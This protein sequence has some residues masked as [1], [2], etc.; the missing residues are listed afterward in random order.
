MANTK[1]GL[2]VSTS[3][4]TS[5]CQLARPIASR[6]CVVWATYARSCLPCHPQ[7]VRKQALAASAEAPHTGSGELHRLAFTTP[8]ATREQQPSVP[9]D[10]GTLAPPTTMLW[11]Q[12]E[13]GSGFCALRDCCH[14]LTKNRAGHKR[15]G[16]P[17]ATWQT[18]RPVGPCC[19]RGKL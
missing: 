11:V 18:K 4:H 12:A 17:S 13:L 9:E 2:H 5:S 6:S 15:T 19:S 7:R 1:P 8:G 3:R 10:A 14:S 16:G